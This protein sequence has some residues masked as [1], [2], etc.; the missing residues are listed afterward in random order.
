M[1]LPQWLSSL[2]WRRPGLDSWVR[3]IPWRRDRLPT[4]VFLGFPSGSAGKESACNVGDQGFNPWIG[5]I[6]WR[7]E[8]LP[9]PVSWPG[10]FHGLYSLWGRKESDT[11]EQLSLLF[12]PFHQPG[13]FIG[14]WA[15]SSWTPHTF[16][17]HLW[18]LKVTGFERKDIQPFCHFFK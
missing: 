9:T 3:K 13:L 5:K 15:A 16:Q 8:R 10:E 2:Q 7:R 1:G 14:F 6:P 12:F 4:P 11:T 18:T 17:W